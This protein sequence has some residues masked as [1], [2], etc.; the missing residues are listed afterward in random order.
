MK[1]I[2]AVL[3]LFTVAC[4][5]ETINLPDHKPQID[6]NTA[7]SKLNATRNDLQ[8]LQIEDLQTRVSS[9]E[10]RM[11]DAEDAIDANEEKI[12]E[13]CDAVQILDSELAQL[14]DD[15]RDAVREL[16]RADRRTRRMMRSRVRSLRRA[17][18]REVRARQLAD[19]RLQRDIDSVERDLNR[20]EARQ[21]IINTI[22]GIGLFVTNQRI[23]QLQ[24]QVQWAIQSINQRLS[25]IESEIANIN[26]E[27]DTIQSNMAAMQAQLDDVESRL[28][29]VVYPCGD[30]NSEEVLLDTQD[31]LVAYFQEMQ[32]KTLTFSDTV[33]V[34]A[35][36][37]P[38]HNDKFCRDTNFFDGECNDY[39]YRHVGEH[40]IPAQT[41]NVGDTASVKVLKKAYLDVLADGNY[42]TTDGF[43]C[44]FTISNGEVQ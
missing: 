23:N 41:Y 7:L 36:T 27:I 29:S 43:S 5:E 40:T 30:G 12:S 34:D 2:L 1:Y 21:S 17:L 16:R 33:T 28:V 32:N 10:T 24:N 39:G 6:A 42:R 20:F 38:A 9:L 8:D 14:R 15:F 25:T 31:G 19:N 3:L 44:N 35:Y 26:S 37:I 22:L 18:L 4:S 13:L 11:D